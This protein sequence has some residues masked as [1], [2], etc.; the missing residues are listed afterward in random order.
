MLMKIEV[1]DRII[2]WIPGQK[3]S[4]FQNITMSN[5]IFDT[6]FP[7][8]PIWPG[9]LS[10]MAL[11]RLAEGILSSQDDFS[12]TYQLTNL[13]K[14]KWRSYVQPGDRMHVEVE[15]ID[16]LNDKLQMKGSI[17][18]ADKNVVTVGI[19]SFQAVPTTLETKQCLASYWKLRGA[20]EVIV[21]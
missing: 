10:I 19:M 21:V 2:D 18:V 8:K 15:V 7:L 11:Q 12:T 4:G 16:R 13:G 5:I 14:I 3:A 20:Q 17:K 9:M 1:I 6:H